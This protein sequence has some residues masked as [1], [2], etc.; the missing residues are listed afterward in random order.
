MKLSASFPPI[1]ALLAFLAG[2]NYRKLA[3]ELVLLAATIAAVTV[4]VVSFT[5]K[6]AK[7]LWAEHGDSI[8]LHFELFIEWLVGAIQV[9]YDAGRAFR[10]VAART[11]NRAADWLYYQ[12][13]NYEGQLAK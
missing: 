4:A 10:P 8:T 6:H 3:T 13:A 1:D 5:W 9:T 12:L 11:L 7:R 2:I